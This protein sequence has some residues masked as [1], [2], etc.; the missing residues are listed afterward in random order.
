MTD[1]LRSLAQLHE[2][3]AGP[4]HAFAVRRLGDR[5]SAEEAVQDT[6]LKAWRARDRFDPDRGSEAAWLFAIA[7]NVV[8]DRLRRRQAR[9]V[10]SGHFDE[11][12]DRVADDERLEV[13]RLLET[14]QVADA[15]AGLS[16][17]HRDALV[18]CHWRGHSIAE[19]AR[20]LDVPEGTVKSRV[21]YGL[22]ALRLQLE[23]QG[24][25]R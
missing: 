6:L 5:E 24:V 11:T 12:D 9:P 21:Y 17:E 4:L 19:A 20:L 2:D 8:I 13:D 22:R 18:L 15:L 1:K 10:S 7:R 23:E 16:V 3:W 25:I 14:W